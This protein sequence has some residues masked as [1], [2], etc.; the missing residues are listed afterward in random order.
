MRFIILLLILLVPPFY[1]II[2]DKKGKIINKTGLTYDIE[3][4]LN[5]L[6]Y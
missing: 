4:F 5:F 3:E 1:F 2:V 6:N